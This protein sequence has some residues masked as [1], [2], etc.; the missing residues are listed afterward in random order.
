[1]D[2][3]ILENNSED[4]DNHEQQVLNIKPEQMNKSEHDGN[5]GRNLNRICHSNSNITNK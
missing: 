3:E 5:N 2:N 1:M 4:H